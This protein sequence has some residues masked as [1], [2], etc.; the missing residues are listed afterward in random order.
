MC[1]A[2]SLDVKDAFNTL[3]CKRILEAI[4]KWDFPGYLQKITESYLMDRMKTYIDAEGHQMQKN[5]S[6]GVPRGSVLEPLLWNAS[7]DKVLQLILPRRLQI[8]CFANTTLLLV[9]GKTEHEVCS[10]SSASVELVIHWIQP[11]RLK[12]SYTA[13]GNIEVSLRLT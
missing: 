4:E 6:A 5:I 8:I 11:R 10:R 13:D 12:Q 3:S 7:F 2:L 1:V 9:Q